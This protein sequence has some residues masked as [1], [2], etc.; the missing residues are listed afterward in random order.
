MIYGSKFK[1]E[2]M[3]TFKPSDE[4]LYI[5]NLRPESNESENDY[6]VF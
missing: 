6:E 3:A 2:P 4:E 5:D 1:R